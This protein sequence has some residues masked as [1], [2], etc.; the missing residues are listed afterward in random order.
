MPD[1]TKDLY[2][3]NANPLFNVGMGLLSSRY[4]PRVNPFGAVMSGLNTSQLAAQRQKQWEQE[5]TERERLEKMRAMVGGII[6][7]TSAVGHPGMQDGPGAQ[8]TPLQQDIA[9]AYAAAAQYGNPMDALTGYTGFL[10]D[11]GVPGMGGGGDMPKNIVEWMYYNRMSEEDQKRYLEMKRGQDI[12]TIAGNLYRMHGALDPT[13]MLSTLAQEGTAKLYMKGQEGLGGKYATSYATLKT[14]ATNRRENYSEALRLR[15]KVKE[16]QL[17]T[18]LYTGALY[19]V[20]PNADQEAL[21]SL[22]LMVARQKLTVLEPGGRYTDADVKT[23]RDAMF[24]SFRTEDFNMQSLD[25]LIR[26]IEALE[27]EYQYYG[28]VLNQPTDYSLPT[29]QMPVPGTQPRAAGTFEQPPVTGTD[30]EDEVKTTKE[31]LELY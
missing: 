22:S 30:V 7:D 5:E 6:G 14:D 13:D 19:K 16:G 3:L 18:G 25:R 8:F 27:Y 28:K 29:R 10:D 2:A 23:L 11:A 15:D 24:G 12:Q 1:L 20:L 4:D 17:K 31:L 9:R 21:D 26:E